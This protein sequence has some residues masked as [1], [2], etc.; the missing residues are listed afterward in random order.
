MSKK[1]IF[2]DIDGTMLSTGGA[3]QKAMELALIEDFA[4]DFPFEGVLTAGR[5]D[6][7]IED[8]IFARYGLNDTRSERDR[9]RRSYLDRLPDCLRELQGALL[10]GVRELLEQLVADN[11]FHLSLLT[12][13]YVEGAQVKL[14]H[15]QL[16]EFFRGC[17]GFGD[18]HPQRNDVA[19]VALDSVRMHL[20]HNVPGEHT[21]VIGD[22]PADI[23]CARA[24]N[25]SVIAV[26]T[27]VYSA[28]QLQPHSPDHLFP[29]LHS[30]ETVLDALRNF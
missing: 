5:T 13:N 19:R 17:G 7:G 9:F 15:F 20:S 23:K 25:A 24:I 6:A 2:F 11:Q 12:G 14:R 16:H 1:V 3:G 30:T 18:Y 22:T 21:C 4:I 8:E 27:G 28:E 29:D 10:P 26:A